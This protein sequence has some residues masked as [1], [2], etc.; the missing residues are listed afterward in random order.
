MSY[1]SEQKQAILEE[2]TTQIGR[3]DGGEHDAEFARRFFRR[4]PTAELAEMSTDDLAALAGGFLDFARQRV[5]DEI[6]FRVYNPNVERHG[7]ES[8][9]TVIEIVNVDM[10]FLVDSVVLAL[11][12]LGI[13]AHLII[14]PVMRVVRDQGGHLLRLIDDGDT[15]TGQ[16]ESMMHLQVDRQ[17]YPEMLAKIETRI[18]SAL[19][20]VRRAVADWKPMLARSREIAAELPKSHAYLSDEARQEARDFFEWLADDHFTFLG[21]REYV[22]EKGT[23]GWVLRAIADSGLGIMHPS[24]RD[25]P[26]RP[27]EELGRGSENPSPDDPIIIT[28]TNATS[29]V[30]RGGY[31]DYI[32]VLYF[33]EDGTVTGEKRL[34][35]MFTSGAYIR[36]CQDTPLVRRKVADVVEM[37]GLQSGSHAGKALMHILETLPRDELFQASSEELLEMAM[38]ILDLQERSQTRL[39]IRRERFGR[40][41]SCLVFI[42]RD[43]FN[44]ENREK[45]QSILKRAL[46]G[47]RL[48]FAVQVGE[49]KLARVHLVVRP[50]G[51]ATVDFDIEA[52][53]NRIK[54]AIRSWE[55][56]LTDILIRDHGEEHGLELARRFG[57]AF[58][59]SYVDDVS[60]H[61]AGYDVVKVSKLRDL[62]DLRMSL[63]K[64][65][66]RGDG[67]LRFKVFKHGDPL[68]LSDVL[69]MLENLGMR[70]V[71]ERPYEL[72]VSD[73]HRV[74][75][76]D[77]DMRPPGDR[78]IQLD[79]VRD[80]FQ[81]AFEQIWRRRC[82]NDGF[83]RLVMLAG[84]DWRQVN[85]LRACSK[86]LLQTGMP[87][88]QNYMEQTLATW[89]LVARLLVE[90]F[91]LRFDPSRETGGKQQHAA[92]SKRL[93]EVCEELAETYDDEVL[94]EYLGN[95][96]KARGADQPDRGAMVVRKAILRAVDSVS[97]AD[98][99]RILRAFYDLIRSMLRTNVYQRDARGEWHEYASFKLDSSIVPELPQPRPWREIWVYSPR[100]EGIH[101]RGGP[102][103]RGGLRWSDRRE[104]FRTEVLGLMRAQSVKNTMIVPVGAKGGFVAKQLPEG[105][106]RDAVMAEVVYCYRSF[107]NGLLDITDNLNGDEL[108]PPREVVRH[109]D[110]DPYLV[111]AADKGTATF[112]DIA[113]AISAEH[114]FWLGD[115]FASGGSNG[116]DHK[117][118]GITAK[119]AWESVKRHF[120]E[121]GLDTQNEDFTVVGIGDMAGD[122]FGNGMLLSEH[123][124]LKAAFNHMHIFLDP[125]PDAAKS[126]EERKRLFELPRST[127]A[128]YDEKLISKGGGVFSRQAKSIELSEEV[129]EWLGI[130]ETALAPHDLIK[131]MLKAPADL[132]WNGGIGTYVKGEREAH[133]DVG[134]LANNLVRING[135]EIGA[136]V[137]GEGGNLGLTQLGRIEYAMVDGRINTDFIDNS[138]GVDCSDHEVNIKILLNEAVE[139]DLIELD[140]RNELL[141][142]MT[143]EVSDLVLRSNYLQNQALSMMESITSDR[144]GAEAHFIAVLEHQ[145]IIDRDLEHLP[146]DEELRERVARGQGL[147]RPELSLLLSY[148]KI[149]LYQDLLDSDVPEDPYLSAE[150]KDYFPTP[151]RERFG[152]LMPD[153]RLWREIIATR[154][155]NSIVNRMGAPFVM[156]IRED[157]GANSAM[158]AKAYTVAREIFAARDFWQKIES[159]DNQV[160]ARLQLEAQLEMWNLLR[161]VTRRLITLPGGYAIDISS[162]VERFAPGIR[163]YLEVLPDMLHGELKEALDSRQAELVEAGFTEDVAREVA[164]LRFVYSALDI[165]DEARMQDMEV[166]EVARVYFRLFDFLCLKWLRAQIEDLSVERQWHAHARGHL[167][168]DLYRHHRDLTRR[169]LRETAGEKE[170][171]KTWMASHHEAVERI[172]LMLEEMRNTASRDYPTLQVAVNGLGQLLHATSE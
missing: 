5:G 10:P 99:D 67:L 111:V 103:A 73:G 136:R 45:I 3:R 165:V 171:V 122:V 28:K 24:H 107:I 48:D 1:S 152:E 102:V 120:R 167:R 108:L 50:K 104:D 8:T 81:E 163:R 132:L 145:D 123:I 149:T 109:D 133:S 105:D 95:V 86:Y 71:S 97:S 33:D 138:A 62:D 157:T 14:H 161:Q 2:V 19:A 154:V 139:R 93:R 137:V 49:S 117:K 114:G 147:T 116:Y 47:E 72:T 155:T 22:I 92:A 153:H 84:L 100:V 131:A 169:I 27:L 34:I 98:Q 41:F 42:P 11:S 32:S 135:R 94:H 30:H 75:I 129:R 55:D 134:D 57:K 29:S 54:Q 68:P 156:R 89:P 16:A 106:D 158:V 43:R 7:W 141:A 12:E 21:Y 148:S 166:E 15:D 52:I 44:T 13:S 124:R 51:D 25:T 36:R 96:C 140:E 91:E 37:S 88:S 172:S 112:S 23:G 18:L 146:D 170:P 46:K 80:K 56:D 151:L 125:E 82:E 78:D 164:G 130:E 160:P 66:K 87:F 162:K 4:M 61:V 70:I 115:A 53:E 40:F 58:P 9:H 64:P 6:R 39:F 77:F 143:D 31:M 127:W 20:D 121:L 59:V 83:N 118:M 110:D 26:V 119:G 90:Y 69:P 128:D 142:E 63:Y 126:F 150:L 17:N 79:R 144:L 60:P 101:L 113:N 76:Q 168:D 38:G 159:L 35:G 85:L 74:W 65:R